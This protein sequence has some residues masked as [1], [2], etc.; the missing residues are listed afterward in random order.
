MVPVEERN[1][2]AQV[3]AVRQKT[4]ITGAEDL[5]ERLEELLCKKMELTGDAA[6]SGLQAT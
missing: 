2:A 6:V 3:I 5:R 1:A 4:V